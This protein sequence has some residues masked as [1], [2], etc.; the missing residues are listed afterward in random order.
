M[1]RCSFSR[2][3]ALIVVPRKSALRFA[4]SFTYRFFQTELIVSSLGL[5]ACQ[6]RHA[7]GWR[8]SIDSALGGK[9]A[10]NLP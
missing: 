5:S 2:L 8:P 10:V 3:S 6:M 9:T 7:Q 4:A 1:R